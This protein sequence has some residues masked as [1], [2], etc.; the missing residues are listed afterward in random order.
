MHTEPHVHRARFDVEAVLRH[1]VAVTTAHA[2]AAA[3]V[4][5]EFG[6]TQRTLAVVHA[7][8]RD[9]DLSF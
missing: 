1:L 8:K 4:N 9:P 2:A 3:I 7:R 6:M 5:P